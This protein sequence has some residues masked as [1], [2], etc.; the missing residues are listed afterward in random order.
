MSG[1]YAFLAGVAAVILA[2]IGG[3]ASKS[4]EVKT[5]KKK[6]EIAKDV[7][8]T[9][10]QNANERASIQAEREALSREIETARQNGND[11]DALGRVATEQARIALERI[12]K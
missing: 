8:Q 9:V 3:R 12:N 11:V 7:A 2:W 10:S 1:V 4:K 5:Q 6:V